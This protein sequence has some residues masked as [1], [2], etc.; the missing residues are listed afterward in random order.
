MNFVQLLLNYVVGVEECLVANIFRSDRYTIK[1]KDKHEGKS[2]QSH[3]P[4]PNNEN[5]KYEEK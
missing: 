4:T 3:T 2:M 5:A 1:G